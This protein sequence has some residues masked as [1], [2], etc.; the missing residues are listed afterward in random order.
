MESTFVNHFH[1]SVKEKQYQAFTAEVVDIVLDEKHKLFKS[2]HSL[3]MIAFKSYYGGI[4]GMAFPIDAYDYTIPLKH[5]AVMIFQAAANNAGSTDESLKYFYTS[6][7]NVWNIINC[8][9][10]PY[11]T[12]D[13]NKNVLQDHPSEFTGV[14]SKPSDSV[15]YGSY[16]KEKLY[17]PKLKLFE[18]DRLYQGRWGQSI[19][20]GS[21][22]KQGL[23]QWSS[24]GE[25]GLPLLILRVNQKKTSTV[26]DV[27]TEDINTDASSMYIC[28]EV[29]IPLELS[30]AI[31]NPK[32]IDPKNF[33][34][35]QIL[36]SSD[37]LV[38][39]A[40]KDGIILSSKGAI[41]M[42]SDSD[43]MIGKD[44]N[45]PATLGNE[46][47]QVFTDLLSELS[48]LCTTLTSSNTVG[49]VSGLSA[50]AASKSN[51][52]SI[53]SNLDKILS[54]KITIE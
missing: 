4:N 19:R 24:K 52:E 46:T 13:I 12:R 17:V 18:G 2:N 44:P 5:E 42:T 6:P 7:V 28:D 26:N 37:R 32:L 38:F 34:G 48:T 51:F 16:F 31:S 40:K 41:H 23:N 15:S 36:M 54:K 39:N 11:Y 29:L 45:T 22:V 20:F 33:V 10:V 50:A 3:G 9:L 35:K 30:S 14:E 47:L 53:K 49:T 43:I 21:I 1:K 8:N 27:T 25:L